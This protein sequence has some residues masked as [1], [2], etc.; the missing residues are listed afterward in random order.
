MFDFQLH[1][2][3]AGQHELAGV[4]SMKVVD[5][6]STGTRTVV[7]QPGRAEFQL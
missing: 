7:T 2:I 4:P 1:K 6:N 3:M 5:A